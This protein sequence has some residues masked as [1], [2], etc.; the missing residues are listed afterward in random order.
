M[1]QLSAWLLLGLLMLAGCQP[2]KPTIE[3]PAKPV[4]SFTRLAPPPQSA[5]E[6]QELMQRAR[7][8]EDIEQILAELDMMIVADMPPISDEALFRKAELM[9]ELQLLGAVE[10]ASEAMLRYPQHAL[11]P[12]AHFWLAKYWMALDEGERALEEMGLALGHPRLTRELADQM[13]ALGSSLVLEVPEPEGVKWLLAA[14][15][16]DQGG[17][18]SWLRLAARRASIATI[19]SLHADGTLT[20]ELMPGFDLHA[21]R[22]Y[23]MA[24]DQEALARMADLM[25]S[26]LPASPE[27]LQVRAWAA[28][29]VRAATIGVL[30]PLSGDYARY[31]EEALRGI[32]MALAGMPGGGQ[33][34][35][36]VEDTGGDGDKAVAAYRKLVD[37]Q[38]D[39]VLGPLLADVTG[40]LASHLR[41]DVPVLS[42]TGRTD[43]AALSPALFVHTLSPL[44]QVGF[45]ARYA[46]QQG[47]QRMVVIAEDDGNGMLREAE[48]FGRAFKGLGGEIM[49]TLILQPGIKDHR[50][51]LRRLRFE[52]D[53]EELLAELDEDLALLLPEMNVEITLPVHF[54]AIYLVMP[55]GDVAVLA[56]QLAYTGIRGVPLYGSSRWVD[57]HLLDDRGRYLSQARFA[58][59]NAVAGRD[60]ADMRR[61]RFMYREAWGGGAPSELTMLAYDSLLI[62]AVMSSRLGL[63]GKALIR[64]LHDAEGFPGIT[65]HVRFDADGVGQK[66]PGI[67]GI[68]KGKIV[69]AG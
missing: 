26:F 45:M 56:G 3:V 11:V 8:G 48:Q 63:A 31:G 38:V 35:L 22:K 34:S 6:I 54:D 28:G 18:D 23:L 67:Y 30:L 46:W 51:E 53:D 50:P 33:I 27:L 13:L 49:E 55:G 32:R 40:A 2:K 58:G 65:G 43:L 14:A 21:A 64:E 1:L 29:E 42:L 12:Y 37:E 68:M 47:A 39:A 17:R 19:E 66:L 20:P 62:V 69:P 4:K 9:L 59:V 16:V 25:S 24:G 61:L 15:R 41:T 52:T 7:L 57:R 44:A 10:A 60:D 36:R 5:T